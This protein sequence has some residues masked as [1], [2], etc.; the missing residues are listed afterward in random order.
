MLHVL[1]IFTA[2]ISFQLHDKL[3]IVVSV[4]E[5]TTINN[6]STSEFYCPIGQ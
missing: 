6:A 1:K 3:I 4:M 5:S 2:V